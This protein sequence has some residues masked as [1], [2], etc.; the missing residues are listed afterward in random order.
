VDIPKPQGGTRPLG[1]PSVRD[2]VAQQAAKLVLEPIF[3]ADFLPCSYG[4]RPKRSATPP[5]QWITR[6]M[7]TLRISLGLVFAGGGPVWAD[8]DPVPDG[9]LLGADEDVFDQQPQHPLA[10]CDGGGCGAGA[11]PGQEAFQVVGELEVGV[12]VGGLDVEG[13]E[14]AAQVRLAGAQVRHPGPQLVDGDQLLGQR[15]DHGGDRRGGF[16]QCGFQAV[17]LA[18]DRAGGPGCFQPIGD[19]G[20][21]QRGI[22]EQERDVVPDHGVEVVGADRLVR[23]TLPFS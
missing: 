15:L 1:I 2:R 17:A 23:H 7:V 16:G 6:A 5:T 4:F 8:G 9:D 13:V 3:E 18:G 12:L 19:L 20:A 14:L 10:F 22:G 11:Q 21:D